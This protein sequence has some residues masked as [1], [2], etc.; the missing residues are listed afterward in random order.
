MVC[1]ERSWVFAAFVTCLFY[2]GSNFLSG[3]IGKEAAIPHDAGIS[4]GQ[5]QLLSD[6]IMGLLAAAYLVVRGDST[7]LMADSRAVIVL[8][9]SGACFATGVVVLSFALATDFRMGPFITGVLPINAVFL[10]FACRIFLNEQ[11][12]V[13]QVLAIAVAVV[14]LAVM[15]TADFSAEGIKGIFFGL[16]TASCFTVG[17]FGIK[18]VSLRGSM[19]H[20]SSVSVLLGAQGAVGLVLFAVES[21]DHGECL[22]GLGML[23]DG[24]SNSRLYWFSALSGLQ[25]AL[26]IACMKLTV[27]IGPAAPGMAIANAN[28]VAVLALNQIFFSPEINA[29]QIG[30]LLVC[31]IGIGI[32]SVA[33]K[34]QEVQELQQREEP[35]GGLSDHSSSQYKELPDFPV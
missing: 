32:L 27:S 12:T 15:A 20:V 30:G 14:G 10:I 34:S 17:N 23:K 4:N 9:L 21:L 31:I 7:E 5:V 13:V 8:L 18:Y 19:S 16:I 11:T 1:T 25:Q 6:G 2:G 3:V 24:T 33:P 28:A 22:S 35:S 29:Q 26:A